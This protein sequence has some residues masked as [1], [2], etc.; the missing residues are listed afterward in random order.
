MKKLIFFLALAAVCFTGYSQTKATTF[1]SAT[2]YY[3]FSMTAADTV[4]QSTNKWYQVLLNKP[5][6]IRV[7]VQIDLD[8]VSGNG[9]DTIALQGKVF[10]GDAWT[11]IDDTIYSGTST[12]TLS[13][14]SADLY[15]RY[16]RI[17]VG[18]TSTTGKNK[19]AAIKVKVWKLH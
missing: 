15:Y 7:Q 11:T 10:S 2:Y 5:E 19:L 18:A 6:P 9:T 13:G 16:L 4:I 14:I 12:V 17:Y 3:E 8:S 1:N